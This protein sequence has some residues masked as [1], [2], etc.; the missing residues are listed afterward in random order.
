MVL[1]VIVVFG[2]KDIIRE[3]RRR[4]LIRESVPLGCDVCYGFLELRYAIEEIFTKDPLNE[5]F[6]LHYVASVICFS[7]CP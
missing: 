1:F 2:A 5:I 6:K 7:C 3:L 4:E